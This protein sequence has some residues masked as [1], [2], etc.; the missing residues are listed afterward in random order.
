MSGRRNRVHKGLFA[1]LLAWLG[2]VPSAVAGWFVLLPLAL[3]GLLAGA[4]LAL[5][6]TALL[7][8]QASAPNDPGNPGGGGSGQVVPGPD[9]HPD[10]PGDDDGG[11]GQKKE[12]QRGSL[13]IRFDGPIDFRELRYSVLYRPGQPAVQGEKLYLREPSDPEG[14]VRVVSADH[15][16]QDGLR[17]RDLSFDSE[18]LCK[19]GFALSTAQPFC[20][21]TVTLAPEFKDLR[22]TRT[23]LRVRASEFAPLGGD[24]GPAEATMVTAQATLRLIN[25]FFA[26]SSGPPRFEGRLLR[27]EQNETNP[28]E[29]TPTQLPLPGPG[30]AALEGV[31]RLDLSADR[32]R[33]YV[34]AQD[35][36]YSWRAGKPD[37]QLLYRSDSLEK[38][39]DATP[40]DYGVCVA[41]LREQQSGMRCLEQDRGY[42]GPTQTFPVDLRV[43]DM[44][45]AGNSLLLVGTEVQDPQRWRVYAVPDASLAWME[46]REVPAQ[47]WDSRR[48]EGAIGLKAWPGGRQDFL[49]FGAAPEERLGFWPLALEHSALDGSHPFY[50]ARHA[51][52]FPAPLQGAHPLREVD[53]WRGVAPGAVRVF[54]LVGGIGEVDYSMLM[55]RPIYSGRV[56]TQIDSLRLDT[57]RLLDGVGREKHLAVAGVALTHPRT[58]IALLRYG[59]A[60]APPVLLGKVNLA[61]PAQ[62]QRSMM[63]QA[64]VRA[65]SQNTLVL[66][67]A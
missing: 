65:I 58:F 32:G 19:R 24:E 67:P 55:D 11:G 61:D 41:F 10:R 50:V 25:T 56:S 63:F 47:R 43:T 1:M 36:L 16:Q 26:L 40:T 49:L 34:L 18:L 51:S 2:A 62:A 59:N 8:F 54:S 42:W 44:S 48:L 12:G 29:F 21:G 30:G 37:L 14:R 27:I 7:I 20:R 35:A 15:I 6:L 13:E 57:L 17:Y 9:R 38:L 31:S 3:P 45:S 60:A 64:R 33:L 23:Q 28:A 5:G 4:L 66:E 53:V 46:F 39:R 52:P 22:S